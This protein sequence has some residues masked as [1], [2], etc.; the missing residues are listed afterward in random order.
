MP[1]SHLPANHPLVPSQIAWIGFAR[2]WAAVA[3]ANAVCHPLSSLTGSGVVLFGCS[4]LSAMLVLFGPD[5][6]W[7]VCCLAVVQIALPLF[8]FGGAGYDGQGMAQLY[9]GAFVGASVLVSMVLARP[10]PSQTL[11]SS[12][13]PLLRPLLLGWLV[14]WLA[15][16]AFAKINYDYLDPEVSVGSMYYRNLASN[17]VLSFLPGDAL[18]DWLGIVAWVSL[19]MVAA[20]LMVFGKTR[21]TGAVCVWVLVIIPTLTPGLGVEDIPTLFLPAS[22]A[23]FSPRQFVTALRELGGLRIWNPLVHLSGKNPLPYFRNLLVFLTATSVAAMLISDFSPTLSHVRLVAVWAVRVLL[24]LLLLSAILAVLRGRNLLQSPPLPRFPKPLFA[25]LALFL[26]VEGLPYIGAH[27]PDQPSM[28][29]PSNVRLRPADS[30]H[31]LFARIPAIGPLREVSVISSDNPLL[32]A[33]QHLPSGTLRNYILEHLEKPVTYQVSG[34]VRER[35]T[36]NNPPPSPSLLA[37]VVP[38]RPY[39]PTLGPQASSLPPPDLTA[40]RWDRH[41]ADLSTR[42]TAAARRPPPNKRSEKFAAVETALNSLS[43]KTA[44]FYTLD[45]SGRVGSSDGPSLLGEVENDHSS[46]GGNTAAWVYHNPR[47]LVTDL[48]ASASATQKLSISGKTFRVWV[49]TQNGSHQDFNAAVYYRYGGGVPEGTMGRAMNRAFVARLQYSHS[50][51]SD[52]PETWWVSPPLKMPLDGELFVYK[53]GVW[54][55]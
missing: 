6:A 49:K 16:S 21:R 38:F 10:C 47:S 34:G 36:S 39:Y 42:R 35:H 33:E 51:F 24:A 26:L 13:W 19:E 54:K 15:L 14:A 11:C 22:L 53:I 43:S 25:M 37:R 30:N 20:F 5:K 46:M 1:P 23:A 41:V 9:S 44:S 40:A 18:G 50:S 12:L 55:K 27:Y 45:P 48:P 28:L 29:R 7:A 52:P 3:L 2:A 32:E 31:V 4:A 8:G 17:P